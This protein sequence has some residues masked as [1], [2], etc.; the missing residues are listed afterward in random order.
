MSRKHAPNRRIGQPRELIA[1]IV[2]INE[3]FDLRTF[4]KLFVLRRRADLEIIGYEIVRQSISLPI[5]SPCMWVCACPKPTRRLSGDTAI[6]M[7]GFQVLRPC[8]SRSDFRARRPAGAHAGVGLA[9]GAAPARR[10]GSLPLVRAGVPGLPPRRSSVPCRPGD[11]PSGPAALAPCYPGLGDGQG[12]SAALRSNPDPRRQIMYHR[13]ATRFGRNSHQISGREALDNEALYRHVPSVFAREAHDSRSDR[14]VYVPTIEIVEGLRKEGWFPFFAVQSVP[15]DGSRHG[16]AKHMLRLRRDDGIGKPEAAEV[17]IVNS[18]DGTSAYQMFA[19]MLR[20]VCTNSMIA[21]ERF[22]EV[23]VPH[24]GG[25]QDRIIEGVYTVA[26]DFPRLIDATETMKDTRLSSDEQR[27]LAEA[28]LVAR[29]GEDESP[30]RPDQ[31]IAPRRREDVGQSL[32]S[33]FNVIQENL[34]RGGLDGRRTNAEGRIR[35]SQTR[36]INGIDQN[37]GL[38]RALWTLAEGMQRLKRG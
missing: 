34:I 36:A 17:I 30:V 22:E 12:C 18:H 33:T 19:G 9:R 20:F 14:Y 16:H 23:R 8:T 29:Y 24:K 13:L 5:S 25:I 10:K 21:G 6:R 15:R 31:I 3:A 37:V 7:G 38:N 27:V 26:E 2:H 28:S 1:Q 32:W 4:D 35:R 11:S